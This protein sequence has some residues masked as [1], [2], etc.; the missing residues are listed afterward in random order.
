MASALR[1]TVA[2]IGTFGSEVAG[3]LPDG[4]T[5]IPADTTDVALAA[6]PPRTA[7]ALISPVPVPRVERVLSKAAHLWRTRFLPVV[8]DRGRLRIGPVSAPGVIGCSEC[9]RSRSRQHMGSTEAQDAVEKALTGHPHELVE[10]HLPMTAALAASAVR[11]FPASAAPEPG[12]AGELRVYDPL[13]QVMLRSTIV[14]VHGCRVCAPR[15]DWA[16]RSTSRLATYVPALLPLPTG[17]TEGE[18]R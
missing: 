1:M 18:E 17:A 13:S 16:E 8:I 3:L 14:G 7:I 12:S 11:S 2:H 10:G 6:I 15:R 9:Y 5:F 4:T